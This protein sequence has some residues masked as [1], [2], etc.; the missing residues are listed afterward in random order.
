MNMSA[1]RRF[2]DITSDEVLGMVNACTDA[3]IKYSEEIG[4]GHLSS[5]NSHN[6]YAAIHN[7][8]T[9]E[10]KIASKLKEQAAQGLRVEHRPI[11][12]PFPGNPHA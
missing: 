2:P 1:T 8:I 9:R 7:A 6:L 4:M 11:F 12:E 3:A 10:Y 5:G